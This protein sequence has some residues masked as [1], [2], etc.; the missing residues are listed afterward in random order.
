MNAS[1]ISCFQPRRYLRTASLGSSLSP[2]C[3]P[4]WCFF[5]KGGDS[6][7]L[8]VSLSESIASSTCGIF[9]SLC[10]C[11]VRSYTCL[12]RFRI[13]SGWCGG[14]PSCRATKPRSSSVGSSQ[15]RGFG[16]GEPRDTTESDNTEIQRSTG[17]SFCGQHSYI[18]QL[19]FKIF[20]SSIII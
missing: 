6:S 1:Q 10:A 14:D 3:V 5:M 17:S 7:H 2:K 13:V 12:Y 11:V 19:P 18:I 20:N 9:S 15:W 4:R 8:L 16:V